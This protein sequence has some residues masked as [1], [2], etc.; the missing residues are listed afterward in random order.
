MRRINANPGL[1]D[2]QL[3]LGQLAIK[4]Q[5]VG[6]HQDPAGG[7]PAPRLAINC[8]RCIQEVCLQS[9]LLM[10]LLYLPII[11]ATFPPS[12]LVSTSTILSILPPNHYKNI[13]N[14]N[15]ILLLRPIPM[16][17]LIDLSTTCTS[18]Y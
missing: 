17:L 1:P 18:N 6:R 8:I 15:T 4:R 5:P 2:S 16:Y 10:Y 3:M 7:I 12:L 14:K 9:T 11:N 13:P